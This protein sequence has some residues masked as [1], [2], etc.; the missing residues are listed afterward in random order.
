MKLGCTMG[1]A[2]GSDNHSD[3]ALFTN[4]S[5]GGGLRVLRV[6]PRR[7]RRTVVEPGTKNLLEPNGRRPVLS[8]G[9]RD[10]PILIRSDPLPE[11]DSMVRRTSKRRRLDSDTPSTAHGIGSGSS[12]MLQDDNFLTPP[13]SSSNCGNCGTTQSS[14]WSRSKLLLVPVCRPCYRY[15]NKYCKSRPTSLAERARA[16][17]DSSAVIQCANCASVQTTNGWHTSKILDSANICSACDHYERR[18]AKCRPLELVQQPRRTVD[19]ECGNCGSHTSSKNEWLRSALLIGHKVCSTCYAY[20]RKYSKCRPLSLI[21]RA[22]ERLQSQTVT[23]CGNCR[24][25]T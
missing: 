6:L 12:S 8:T 25:K 24:R 23:E 19:P 2:D 18:H 1:N 16:R 9:D 14:R 4:A 15:E 13:S 10:I 20:E 11:L 17:A 3:E 5:P 21:R 7:S 22:E